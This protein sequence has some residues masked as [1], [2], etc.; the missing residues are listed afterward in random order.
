MLQETNNKDT[1]IFSTQEKEPVNKSFIDILKENT[2]VLAKKTFIKIS[3]ED[4]GLGVF[5]SED[6]EKDEIIEVTPLIQLGWRTRYQ[7]DPAITK[8][9]FANSACKCKEC[10]DHGNI[11]YFMTGMGPIYNHS[12]N[13]NTIQKFQY[14]KH[15]MTVIAKEDIKKGQ[16][17]FINYGP[18][19]FKNRVE[20]LDL[21]KLNNK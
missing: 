20:K 1:F 18:E 16:E 11:L 2:Y 8:Y 12:D 19:Y 14:S 7:R 6:I 21:I 17:I 4:V 15:L 10:M 3:H 5:A 13:P 9:A